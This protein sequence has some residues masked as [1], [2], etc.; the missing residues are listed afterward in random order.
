M[1]VSIADI[2]NLKKEEMQ[3]LYPFHYNKNSQAE[4]R[5]MKC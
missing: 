5:T 3:G 1:G 2:E 4:Y